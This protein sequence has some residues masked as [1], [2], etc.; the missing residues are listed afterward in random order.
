MDKNIVFFFWATPKG[1]YHN[2]FGCYTPSH[3]NK[4]EQLHLVSI[5][6]S[7]GIQ[8]PAVSFHTQAVTCGFF[9]WLC[10][11]FVFKI[12]SACIFFGWKFMS[13]LCPHG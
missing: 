11:S 13:I 8:Y 2:V 5:S 9:K 12:S 1:N 6:L 4:P 10:V 7:G 3:T